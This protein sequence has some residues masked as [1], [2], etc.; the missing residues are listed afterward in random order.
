MTTAPALPAA[1]KEL[2]LASSSKRIP[3]LDGLRGLAI[4]LVLVAHYFPLVTIAGD[5]VILRRVLRLFALGWSGVD[6]FFVLSGFLIGGILFESRSSP[7]YFKTFYFRRAYRILPIYSLWLLLYLLVALTYRFFVPQTPIGSADLRHF[8]Y[9]LLFLQNFL[10]FK[11]HLEVIWL[12]VTWSLAIE[13][14]FYLCAPFV[15]RNL[16]VRPLVI[17]LGSLVLIAPL[18]R[19]AVYLWLP[20]QILLVYLSLFCRADALALGMLAAV[21]SSLP[22]VRGYVQAHPNLPRNFIIGSACAL[23]AVGY[24]LLGPR[25]VISGTL[26]FSCLAFFYLSLLVFVLLRPGSAI[27]GATRWKALRKLG[28]ISYC[29]YIIH[30]PVLHAV[31]RIFRASGPS[32]SSWDAVGATCLALFFTLLLAILSWYL[33]EKPLIRRGHRYSY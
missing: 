26:G 30:G 18:L 21:G 7:R 16:R 32:I 6:L 33:L 11:A 19:L 9:Y 29:V 4:L 10:F 20:Q 22:E 25:E 15:V 14:Q 27:A 23:A 12:G 8:P 28:M 17:V 5:H 13:E 31:H 2:H 24:W 3:E 1:A